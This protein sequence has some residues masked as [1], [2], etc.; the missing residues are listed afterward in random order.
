MTFR[1]SMI[2]LLNF[3][4]I[5]KI[6]QSQKT[7][8]CTDVEYGNKGEFKITKGPFK[9][10]ADLCLNEAIFVKIDQISGELTYHCISKNRGENV[11]KCIHELPKEDNFNRLSIGKIIYCKHF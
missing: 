4:F 7:P 11:I 5:L 10:P 6:V 9:P 1:I 2:F 8:T 3:W